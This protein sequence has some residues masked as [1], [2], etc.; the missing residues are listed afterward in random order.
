VA[1]SPA[2]FAPALDEVLHLGSDGRVAFVELQSAQ[3]H[4]VGKPEFLI[5]QAR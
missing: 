3:V 2:E 4:F 5:A 1:P